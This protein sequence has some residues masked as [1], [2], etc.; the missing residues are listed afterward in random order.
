MEKEKGRRTQ[1]AI[2]FGAVPEPIEEAQVDEDW[3]NEDDSPCYCDGT[4]VCVEAVWELD[5][6]GEI[7]GITRFHVLIYDKLEE[8]DK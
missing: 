1:N 7:F 3:R 5:Y 4:V 6:H 2:K 8:S